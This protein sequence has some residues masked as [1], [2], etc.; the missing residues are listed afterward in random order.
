[1][2]SLSYPDDV[3]EGKI[4]AL[5]QVF[6]EEERV[7][8]ARVI[9]PNP[10][11]KLKPGMLVD[12]IAQNESA[13]S[14]LSIPTDA[15][16]FDDNQHYAV[17]Y[18]NDCDMEIRRLQLISKNGSTSFIASGLKENEHVI[19]ENQL[20]IYQKIKESKRN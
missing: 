2:R 3:F 1:I 9:I 17:V 20:L 15:L 12:V 16:V 7:L 13:T 11:F 10:D 5:S 19:T 6:D 18:K 8:K 4:A 14:A